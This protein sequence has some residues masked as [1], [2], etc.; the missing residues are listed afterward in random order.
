MSLQGSSGRQGEIPAGADGKDAVV[1]LNNLAV[2]GD[3]QQVLLV[4]HDHHCLQA[5]QHPVGPPVLG[6]LYGCTLQIALML[7]QLSFEL[8]KQ[9]DGIR[10]G[11]GKPSRYLAAVQTANLLRRILHD[12]AVAEGHLAVPGDGAFIVMPDR[13]NRRGVKISHCY[14]S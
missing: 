1:R 10:Y 14:P 9:R 7:L 2:S 11:T 5:A 3:Q 8:L 4:H 13:K 6:Q 12:H